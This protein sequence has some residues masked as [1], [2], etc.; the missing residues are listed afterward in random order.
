[1]GCALWSHAEHRCL[2][3]NPAPGPPAKP[4]PTATPKT[5]PAP[6]P[7]GLTDAAFYEA[8]QTLFDLQ[9]SRRTLKAQIAVAEDAYARACQ[10]IHQQ[11]NQTCFGLRRAIDIEGA[12]A[13]EANT[14]AIIIAASMLGLN[15]AD[16]LR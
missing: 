4:N 6:Q 2:D 8:N 11:V 5:K 14:K 9:Q 1:L 12:A 13:Q 7:A 10:T 3:D 15:T 16:A